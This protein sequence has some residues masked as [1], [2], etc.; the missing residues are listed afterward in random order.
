MIRRVIS[1]IPVFLSANVLFAQNTFTDSSNAS[2]HFTAAE[3]YY[4]IPYNNTLMFTGYADHRSL[5]LET[6]Y[7]YE[8]QNTV[9]VFAG[10]TFKGGKKIQFDVKPMVGILTGNTNGVAPALETSINYK[11]FDLYAE[12]EYVIGVKGNN[13][14]ENDNNYFYVW[15]ELAVTPIEGLRTGITGQRLNLL[16]HNANVQR[17]IFAE[18]SFWKLTTGFYY[19]KNSSNDNL[20]ISSLSV[21]IK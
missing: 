16:N 17:G 6:R 18:Y 5:H 9:S 13:E 19:L 15:W 7:N 20:F 4:F 10:W 8:D 12:S 1:L 11:L 21:R 3:Y 14:K 2:W